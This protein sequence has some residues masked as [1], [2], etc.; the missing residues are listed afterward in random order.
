ME[1]Y[2]DA[3]P[4]IRHGCKLAK[5]LESNLEKLAREPSVLSSCCDEIIKAFGD[6]R[7]RLRGDHDQI[8]QEMRQPRNVVNDASL[9]EWLRSNNC[10]ADQAIAMTHQDMSENKMGS[11]QLLASSIGHLAMDVSVLGNAPS[12]SSSSS[13]RPRKRYESGIQNSFV[14]N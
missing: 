6:A 14:Q 1:D 7:D 2:G 11:A 12:S 3:I 10:Y 9:H 5:E 4:L 8:M 13:Q